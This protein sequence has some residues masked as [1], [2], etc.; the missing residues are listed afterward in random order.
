[1]NCI[2]DN[3]ENQNKSGVIT[4]VVDTIETLGNESIPTNMHFNINDYCH[5]G[6]IN[7]IQA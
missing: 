5:R 1:M 2:L 7:L 6:I 3:C 4:F